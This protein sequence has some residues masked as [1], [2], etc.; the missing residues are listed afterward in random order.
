MNRRTGICA[1]AVSGVAAL[2]ALSACQTPAASGIAS[3]AAQEVAPVQKLP[4]ARFTAAE[5]A[6]RMKTLASD[7]FAGR[8]PGSI[9]E[10]KTI[11]YLIA[12][13]K[14]IGLQ[15]GINGSFVQNVPMI[16]SE[17]D[18]ST[19]L[20]LNTPAGKRTLSF[21]KDMVIGTTT[22][23][24]LVTL[25]DSDVVFVGYGVNAPELGWN[26][27]A[28]L[29]VKGKTVV[30]LVN[31]PGFQIK[32]ENLFEGRRMTYYG[33]WTYKFEEAARQGASAAFIVH[34]NEGA[35]YGWSVVDNGWTGKQFDLTPADDPA[36]RLPI[37]GW[38]TQE[39]ASQLFADA[40]LRLTDQYTSASRKGF[41]AIPLKSK[42]S[43]SLKTSIAMK[44]SQNFVAKLPGTKRPDEAIIYQAHWD[45]LGTN[46]GSAGEDHI[47]NGAVDNASGVAAIMTIAQGFMRASVKP[48]RSL[49]FFAPTLEESGLLGSK[50]F[51]AHPAVPLKNTVAV[52]NIDAMAMLGKARN[53]V[54]I[55]NGMSD[56][57]DTLKPYAAIQGRALA[58]ENTPQ[59][60]FYFRSDHFNFAKAGVPALYIKGGDD[61]IDG[62]IARGR[63]ML[64]DY[65]LN[66][67]HKTSD[68]FDPK[69]NLEGAIQDL[70]VLY[71][72]GHELAFSEKWPLWYPTSAF[73]GAQ[74]ALR[75]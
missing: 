59:D 20:V 53:L 7:E 74:D 63:E 54:I 25:K 2:F 8:A 1:V 72:V 4:E 51:V 64:E 34:D 43:A 66:H 18:L 58:P 56:L 69:W 38:L 70:Q 62:G 33:R 67:Y 29:D 73:R 36:P 39:A 13:A 40:G 68:E 30:I 6:D 26:D 28:G 75:K 16:E 12:Q 17:T 60:G 31:D 21:S 45:H 9:G 11:D 23:K 35:A 41:K 46:D 15:P 52:I 47:Y 50:Y 5:F 19:K 37:R 42:A 49:I 57:E 10:T 55:G 22:G 71:A 32:D 44:S 27:Y 65:R 48:E 24:P 14:S 3:E 61:L